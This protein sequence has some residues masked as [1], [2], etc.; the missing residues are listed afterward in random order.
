MFNWANILA[1]EEH[2]LDLAREAE[3]HRLVRQARERSPRPSQPRLAN[4]LV[5]GSNSPE[6]VTKSL[7][8]L[9]ASKA[10]RVHR[11]GFANWHIL[12]V[13]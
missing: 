9:E 11:T 5:F 8:F 4:R 3:L 10:N 12:I 13:R 1:H 2:L 6:L 7:A